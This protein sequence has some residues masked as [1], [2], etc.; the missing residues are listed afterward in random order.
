MALGCAF[1]FLVILMLFRRRMRKKRAQRTAAF[2]ISKNIDKRGNWRWRLLRFGERLFGHAPSKRFIPPEQEGMRLKKMHAAEEGR[3][4]RQL[5]KMGGPSSLPS[6]YEHDQDSPSQHR[7]SGVSESLYSQVTGAPRR[8]PDPR[9][10]VKD[11]PPMASRFSWTTA[12]SS[13]R[14]APSPVQQTEA[15]KY[16]MSIRAPEGTQPGMYWLEPVNTGTSNSKNP[17]RK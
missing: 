16:A 17:F 12:G 9:Q 13:V 7:Y 3:H 4:Q 10:P 8:V 1:I 14:R 5:E 11:V 6:Y 2:A 15:Q